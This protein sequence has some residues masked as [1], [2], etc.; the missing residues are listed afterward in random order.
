LRGTRRETTEGGRLVIREPDRTIIRQQGQTI[1][2]HSEIDRFRYGATDV[3]VDRRG[4]ETTT[5]VVRPDG[6]RIVTIT[7][8]NGY[9]IRRTR[10]L[11]DR[12]EIVL[13]DNRSRGANVRIGNL[14][15]QLAPPRI[16]IPRERY[17]VDIDRADSRLIY[18]TL[19]APPVD[20]IARPYTLDEIRYSAP[21][22][23][24]MPRIDLNTVTF[25]T[26]SWELTPEQ[27]AKLADIA[28]GINR[29][30]RR[31]PREIF[32]IEGHTDA[33]GDDYDNLSLSDRRAESVAIALSDE[34]DVPPENLATQGYGE[35]QL[36]V[37]TDGPE[38]ANRRV[39]VRRITPL[40][41]GQAR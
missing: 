9:L 37:P 23:D 5:I 27:I 34:F 17:I 11:P 39:T 21:L 6:S 26:G 15:V 1:I 25:D 20:V 3:R 22:R 10:I 31:N 13:I 7:D 14:F 2:R 38:R 8:E 28:E 32:L 41:V 30:I 24:R 33:V 19:I 16:R 29:A 36:K 12:R 35:Q 4:G 18:Q 40:L